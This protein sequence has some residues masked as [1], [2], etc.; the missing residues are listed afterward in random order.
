MGKYHL[1][2]G[3]GIVLVASE[4]FLNLSNACLC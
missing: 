1:Q 4:Y 2:T 3:H